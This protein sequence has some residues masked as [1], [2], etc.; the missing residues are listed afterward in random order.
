MMRRGPFSL[1]RAVAAVLVSGT[2][3]LV[4]SCG[5]DGGNVEPGAAG[6]TTTITLDNP[7]PS[8]PGQSVAVTVSVTSDAGTPTGD[9]TVGVV[10]GTQ[11]CSGALSNGTMTC[12][13]TLISEGAQT[14]TATYSGNSSFIPSS[15][16][17]QHTVA[18]PSA[19][20]GQVQIT[21]TTTGSDLD[22][23][24]YEFS[25]D[26]GPS[27]TIAVNATATVPGLAAG[28]HTVVLSGVSANCTVP[29]GTSKDV[30][31]TG[32]GTA[33]VAFDVTCSPLPPEVGSIRITTNTTG[34]DVDANGYQVSIDGGQGQSIGADAT[35]TIGGVPA[36]AHTIQLSDVAGNCTVANGTSRDVSV[37]P[38]VTAIVD[39][40]VTCTAIPPSTG[41]IR[42]TAATT[43]PDPDANGFRFSIDGGQSQSIASNA[44]RTIGSVP[45]GAHTIQLSDVAGNCTVPNGS[46]K[47]VTVS[48][49]V[50]AIVDFNVTC[51]AI[52]P[53]TGSIRVTTAT[54]GSSPDP[55]G[56]R[57]TIDGGSGR[58]ID[59]NDTQ[60]VGN[61]SVGP[62]TVVLTNVV[63]NCD[64]AG[65]ASKNVS[66]TA[67]QTA[68]A[69]FSVTCT[70]IAP[71]A[72]RS[73]MLADPKTI[74]TG[75]PSTV[76]VTVKDADGAVLPNINVVPS[77]TGD[78]NTF[79]PVSATTNQNGVAT[80]AFSSTAAGDK[81]I[82]AKAGDVTLNDTEVVSVFRRG[83]TIEITGDDN[84]PSA[85]GETFTVTFS[86]TVTGSG[87]PTGTVTIFS[88]E[89]A[90]GCTVPVG[91][92]QCTFAYNNPGLHQL[93]ATYSG[94]S[95]FDESSDDIGVGH[96]VA[97][98]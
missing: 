68:E 83:S 25:V 37:A 14:L 23:D 34:T 43:G 81:T 33:T 27:Q 19:D 22:G 5:G 30:T 50:T 3:A 90:G 66:V 32:G 16:T 79:N 29:G 49:G 38:G 48:P 55:D 63:S 85:P 56:Y 4:T 91:D 7:D 9:V 76:T 73:T 21:T 70:S 20:V 41:S 18:A 82:T 94:D 10:G 84:D 78:G 71:S 15:D 17:E 96:T 28:T 74:A 13:L 24:G 8:L 51:T 45:A 89:E 53:T 54:T 2:V 60:T 67:G 52:P 65:G 95:Q 46:S 62:H 44:T 86:V 75:A 59:V 80:F 57:F 6:T 97:A 69:S 98:P 72:L 12:S 11:S 39:F 61:V 92:G 47:G 26:G 77:A 58:S 36:G 35:S 31:V 64:V 42:I 40:T 1:F 87:T 88:L 93:L